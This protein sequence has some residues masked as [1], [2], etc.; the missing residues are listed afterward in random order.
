MIRII[1]I[2]SNIILTDLSDNDN[3]LNDT[4]FNDILNNSFN[5]T[6]NHALNST[7]TNYP[8]LLNIVPDSSLNLNIDISNQINNYNNLLNSYRNIFSEN[9]ITVSPITTNIL[10]N[11]GSNSTI[12]RLLRETFNDK[13]KYKDVISSEGEKKLEKIIYIKEL[14][15]NTVCPIYQSEFTPGMEVT[16]LPCGHLFSTIG[17]ERWLKEESSLCPV[18]RYKLES[19]EIKIDENI[20]NE[21]METDVSYTIRPAINSLS[22]NML[23]NNTLSNNILSNN[24]LSNVFQQ[25]MENYNN[26]DDDDLQAAI[27]NSLNSSP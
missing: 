11:I 14:S 8:N 24:M 2:S 13:P 21:E 27:F 9:N 18:C 12:N 20:N 17:I 19:K 4:S 5:E 6:L 22:N 3:L 10:N 15:G 16:K 7:Y 25:V 26:Y 1:D 23:S